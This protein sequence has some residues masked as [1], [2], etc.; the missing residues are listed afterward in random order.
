MNKADAAA[1]AKRSV[2]TSASSRSD[3]GWAWVFLL[4]F[5]AGQLVFAFWPMARTLYDSMTTAGPFGGN[6][7][8]VGIANYA[9]L[10]TDAK[11]YR[12]ALNTALFAG[13]LLLSV[14]I[15]LYLAN[16]VNRPGLRGAGFYRVVYFLPY[17]TM[18]TAI[19]LVFKLI[20]NRDF[21]V[22][23]WFLGLFGIQGP[24]W[25][26][27]PWYSLLAV[28]ILGIWST[29]GFNMIILLAGMRRI[30]RS[31]YEAAEIDGAG[32][33]KQFRSITVPLLAPTTFFVSVI[34]LIAGLQ[35]FDLLYALIGPTNPVMAKSQSLVYMFY[36]QG[37]LLHHGGYAAAIA[38]LILVVTGLATAVQF[39]VRRTTD[40]DL[41]Y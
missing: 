35:L 36:E 34:T 20:Y 7:K 26:S 8:W 24:Y 1:H 9:A 25:V 12:A 17:V 18:P 13:L 39:L 27:S 14:P 31:L 16:L 15:A 29:I 10:L 21:G 3:R 28:G 37:F 5:L 41:R 32:N 19:A 4:P 2:S 6:A 40:H 38:V 23:N 30:P 33:W 22:L 11:V